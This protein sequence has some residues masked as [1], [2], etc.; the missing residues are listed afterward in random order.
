MVSLSGDPVVWVFSST[1]WEGG[2]PPARGGALFLT[3]DRAVV[4]GH[5]QAMSRLTRR[6]SIGQGASHLSGR[7]P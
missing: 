3:P 6:H 5:T 2:G 4:V 1:V 7:I